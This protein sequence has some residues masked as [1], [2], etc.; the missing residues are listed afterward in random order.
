MLSVAGRRALSV[1]TVGP[2]LVVRRWQGTA[3]RVLVANFGDRAAPAPVRGDQL[4]AS[5]TFDLP[6][7][8][9]WAAAVVM[10]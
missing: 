3:S 6:T 4:L 8:P 9:P 10:A 5:S 1:E 7:I 2:V